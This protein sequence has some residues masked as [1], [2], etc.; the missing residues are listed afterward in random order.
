MAK[1]NAIEFVW[2]ISK[3]KDSMNR[4]SGLWSD[5]QIDEIVKMGND[6]G[7]EFDREEFIQAVKESGLNLPLPDEYK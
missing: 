2:K 5:D 6:S 1:K 4:V 3:N 7:L